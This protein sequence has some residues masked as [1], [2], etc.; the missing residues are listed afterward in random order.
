[1]LLKGSINQILKQKMLSLESALN[2]NKIS[3]IK[4]T[5]SARLQL[6]N[7]IQLNDEFL[8]SMREVQGLMQISLANANEINSAWPACVAGYDLE[9]DAVTDV[10]Q[11]TADICTNNSDEVLHHKQDVSRYKHGLFSR[12]SSLQHDYSRLQSDY[13]QLRSDTKPILKLLTS[14]VRLNK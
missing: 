3:E 14:Q 7:I 9:R 11:F 13:N 10:D 1:M 5:K 4:D 12:I 2:I 6:R 8:T